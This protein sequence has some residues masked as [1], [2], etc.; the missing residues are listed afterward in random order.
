MA[1]RTLLAWVAALVLSSQ[2]GASFV[3]LDP[4]MMGRPSYAADDAAAPTAAA[5]APV[6]APAQAAELDPWARRQHLQRRATLYPS[7]TANASLLLPVGAS[8]AT[9][10]SSGPQYPRPRAV[11]PA[12]ASSATPMAATATPMLTTPVMGSASAASA[13]VETTAPL[14]PISSSAM[15][16]NVSDVSA[17]TTAPALNA[18]AEAAAKAAEAEAEAE[19]KKAVLPEDAAGA[20]VDKVETEVGNVK[21]AGDELQVRVRF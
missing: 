7:T 19:A 16:A 15:A 11:P 1:A 12:G 9:V 18:T 8:P 6:P 17:I 5:A 13:A 3:K 2:P 4:S 10:A 21:K 14:S 20:A